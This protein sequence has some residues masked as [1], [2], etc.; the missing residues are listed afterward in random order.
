MC[1]L[2]EKQVHTV[3]VIG[4]GFPKFIEKLREQFHKREVV[5]SAVNFFIF[6]LQVNNTSIELP[7]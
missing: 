3:V 1:F 6:I 2:T 4:T 5:V 7:P